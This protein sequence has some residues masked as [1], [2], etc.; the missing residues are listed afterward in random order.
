MEEQKGFQTQ[1]PR[2]EED[3]RE[4]IEQVAEVVPGGFFFYE[5]SGDQ[6]LIYVNRQVLKI[7]G[8]DTLDEFK[9]LTG[10]TFPGMV[11]PEDRDKCELSINIQVA[12]NAERLD[13]L[14]YR[15]VRKDGEVRWVIDYGKFVHS[16]D[17]GNIYYVFIDDITKQHMLQEKTSLESSVI[18]ILS[19]DYDSVYLVDFENEKLETFRA[20]EPVMA[21]LNHEDFENGDYFELFRHYGRVM[22]VPD[23][24]EMFLEEIE[25]EYIQRRLRRDDFY[26][27]NFEAFGEYRQMFVGAIRD[28]KKLIR[29][30]M[31]FRPIT[32]QMLQMREETEGKLRV[33]VELEAAVAREK[34]KTD[35]LYNVSRDIRT[36]MNAIVGFAHLIGK[37]R[38]NPEKLNNYINKIELSSE[39]MLAMINSI[40]EMSVM[41]SGKIYIEEIP[42]HISE[43]IVQVYD[44]M[45]VSAKDKEQKLVKLVNL[46]HEELM[47]DPVHMRRIISNLVQNAIQFTP[48]GGTVEIAAQDSDIPDRTGYVM[49][50]LTVRDNGVGMS[51]D[52]LSKMYEPFEKEDSDERSSVPGAGLGLAITKRIVDEMNGEIKVESRRGR[53]TTFDVYIPLK[54]ADSVEEDASKEVRK[55]IDKEVPMRIL[56]AEDNA[57]NREIAEDILESEGYIVESAVDGIKALEAVES[58]DGYYYSLILMDI[59]MPGM[60]GYETVRRIRALGEGGREGLSTIPI[61]ALSANATEEDKRKAIESGMNVHLA[62]PIDIKEMTDTVRVFIRVPR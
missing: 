52:F 45:E 15:I 3:T 28:K 43:Q 5:A 11:H 18:D 33:E 8:C 61:I 37:N 47:A 2:F 13:N 57:L 31:G 60:D 17:Y 35:F 55:A 50:H 40:L 58:H 59:Q 22:V 34:A 53:G 36:P 30:V 49:L 10:F 14:V 26:T 21:E 42:C 4:I 7:F 62:K 39:Y 9:E 48:K 1:L 46:K 6:K 27:V 25:P 23:D 12:G 41:E 51:R 19:A 16:E 32:D 24:Q 56:L 20:N 44:M 29:A 38:D 54:I